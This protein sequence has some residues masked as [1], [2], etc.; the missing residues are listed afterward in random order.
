MH[1]TTMYAMLVVVGFGLV[2]ANSDTWGAEKTGWYSAKAGDMAKYKIMGGMTQTTEVTK[3]DENFVYVSIS[4]MM[5]SQTIST[6]QQKMPKYQNAGAAPNVE[7]PKP[8]I[9]DLGTE[10]VEI[11]GKKLTCRVTETKMEAEGRTITSKVWISEDVPGGMV[12]MM[13]DAMGK[14]D[15]QME[16]VDFRRGS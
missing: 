4:M 16:L 7:G 8:E 12:R 2:A 5:G 11:S 14:M 9:K 1:K 6:Q 13:S 3:V 15:V 10:M